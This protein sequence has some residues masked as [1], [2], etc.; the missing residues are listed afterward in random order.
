L[1]C[2][3]ID[4]CDLPK[5]GIRIERIGRIFSHLTMKYQLGFK[6]LN[7][8]YWTGKKLLQLDISLH[9]EMGRKQNQGLSKKEQRNRFT[10]QREN[11]DPGYKRCEEVFEKNQIRL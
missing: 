6:S 1:P 2:F 9:G 10:K 8:T 4:D 11:T 3:I 7:L 5:R